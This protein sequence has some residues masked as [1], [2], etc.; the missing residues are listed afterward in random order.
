MP[1]RGRIRWAALIVA[2]LALVAA[3]AWFA[4]D[5]ERGT[6]VPPDPVISFPGPGARAASPETQ[7]SLRGLPA[8]RLGSIEVEGS[9]S[10]QHEGTLEPHSDGRGASF[11]PDEP[12][13]PGEEVSVSTDLTVGGSRNGDFTFDV[14]RPAP[15]PKPVV[16]PPRGKGDVQNFR[17]RLDLAPPAVTVTQRSP[18]AGAGSV[19]LAPKRGRGQ[20]GLMIL[21]N[22][23]KLV[24]WR[25]MAPEGK[26]AADF[27]A[28]RYG[29]RPVL[30]W[31]EGGT[32]IGTGFGEGVILDQSYREVLRVRTGNGYR[33]GLHEFLLTPRG[34][35]LMVIYSFVRADL[36]SVG[37]PED[38][39]V[40]DGVIQEID[41]QTGLVV[42]EWHTL[43]HIRL[44]ES[45][46]PLPEQPGQAH[47]YV[48]LN[49]IAVDMDGDLLLSGRHTW[50]LYKI[51]RETGSVVWRL[52]GKRSD[53]ELGP[54]ADFAF[55]H[56]ARR[57]DDGAITLFDNAA[58]PPATREASRVIALR[59]DEEA[60]TAELLSEFEHPAGGL[61][62]NQ[63]NAQPLPN[64]HLL[65]G[66][67]AQPF[68]TEHARD[69]RVVWGARIA[70]GNDNYR[71]YR[72]R[73]T[74]RPA[75]R[76]AAV[77]ERRDGAVVVTASWNG[78]TE[79]ARWELMAGDS[80]DAL[81][82]AGSVAKRGFETPLRARRPARW[83]A[84]RAIDARG[85][86]LGSSEPVRAP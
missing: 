27:R 29:G 40:L 79:V 9:E 2:L 52:G 71:A 53:F 55:Q 38:G 64:G 66:W 84:A 65:V 19:F 8:R 81:R 60:R 86:V 4:L 47:D 11:V 85:A 57:R 16:E 45:R 58:G 23:G 3:G 51:D 75:T 56:D 62:E 28:Q 34:T 50:A 59:V 68:V 36:S 15:A 82:P 5:A 26:Q 25:A 32:N 17:S 39:A 37:G 44:G 20:D 18:E 72:G 14:A 35:A 74:G 77:A 73:W 10:G 83:Y 54:G 69:G 43:D 6:A 61:S 7:I 21:D 30:T 67:G 63:G 49:S 42:F 1:G 48:H 22:R 70:D 13:S 41:L 76:P 24:W 80:R 31:W 12:F 78:A 46:W 33:A